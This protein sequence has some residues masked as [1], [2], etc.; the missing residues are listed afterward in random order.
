MRKK[1]VCLFIM[2]L[3]MLAACHHLDKTNSHVIIDWVHFVKINNK[4]YE[5]LYTGVL[6][7]E[8]YVG[9]EVGEVTF[10]LNENVTEFHYKAKNGDAAYLE[11]GTKLHAVDGFPDLLAVKNDNVINGYELFI[12]ENATFPA[13]FSDLNI[14]NIKKVDVW[15]GYYPPQ[16]EQTFTGEALEQ[17]IVTG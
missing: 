14:E 16:Y 5:A 6:M 1:I 17:F 7:D 3:F 12:L 8:K 13:D 2:S 4:T 11:E 15:K 9:D 10:T